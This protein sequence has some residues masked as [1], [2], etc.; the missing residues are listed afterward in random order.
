VSRYRA[1][2][3]RRFLDDRGALRPSALSSA[4]HKARIVGARW[5]KLLKVSFG[6]LA[7]PVDAGSG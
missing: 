3:G 6:Q 5:G 7:E 2:I 1:A 4:R